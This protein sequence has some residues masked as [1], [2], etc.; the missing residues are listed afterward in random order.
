LLAAHATIASPLQDV[1]VHWI[2]SAVA[3]IGDEVL[4]LEAAGVAFAFN[5]INRIADARQV[6]L[7]Y[8]FLRELRPIRGWVE[9]RLPDSNTLRSWADPSGVD[10]DSSTRITS[11]ARCSPS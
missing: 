3:R 1:D 6:R 8:R 5:L 7:E 9:R 4:L 10:P 2:A 11:R